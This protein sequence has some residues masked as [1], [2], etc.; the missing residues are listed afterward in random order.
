MWMGAV[1]LYGIGLTAADILQLF[2]YCQSEAGDKNADERVE[3]YVK[4]HQCNSVEE[5]VIKRLSFDGL[6]CEI[7][8]AFAGFLR[9]MELA[10]YSIPHDIAR[11]DGG[12]GVIGKAVCVL[13]N[14]APPALSPCDP[15][16]VQKTLSQ[17][18]GPDRCV[19][20]ETYCLVNTSL[21][22]YNIP[23]DCS[24]CS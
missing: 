12:V 11:S 7:Y 17:I 20:G 13:K 8:A 9:E 24:C 5:F 2:K 23:L 3:S 14:E 19:P 1:S 21:A 22:Y 15:V 18:F 6:L 10:V 16:D 4:S